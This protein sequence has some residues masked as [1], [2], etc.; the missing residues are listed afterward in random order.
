MIILA[1]ASPRRK[2]LLSKITND[3]LV[4]PSTIDENFLLSN[5]NY[6][7]LFEIPEFLATQKALDVLKLH[8]SDTVIGADTI[9]IHNN[10]I[11][12]KPTNKD[13]AKKMLLDFSDNT[14]FVVTAVCIASNSKTISFSS[15]NQVTFFPL[16]NDEIDHYLSFDEYKDKAGSYAI[17][18]KAALFV[19]K[20]SGDY[21]SIIGLPI[22]DIYQ[23]LKN[24]F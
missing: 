8:S 24:F 23:I 18:G 12:G 10:K 9:I 22:S 6:L 20:I 5:I 11:Y 15:I 21:N 2:E 17:Q 19:K 4:V 14:H 1:S 7:S 16:T 3:F 13:D